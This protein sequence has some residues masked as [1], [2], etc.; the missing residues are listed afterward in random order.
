M[1]NSDKFARLRWNCRR[2]ML[3]LDIL[4][5]NF[6]ENQYSLLSETEQKYFEQLLACQDQ[7]LFNWLVHLEQPENDNFK[8]MVNRILSYAHSAS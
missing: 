5:G 7:E 8:I 3:E 1:S 4:L 6:L 2:G